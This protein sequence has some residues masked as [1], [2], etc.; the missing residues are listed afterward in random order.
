M[1]KFIRTIAAEIHALTYC[2]TS[3]RWSHEGVDLIRKMYATGGD[4]TGDE[5]RKLRELRIIR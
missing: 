3:P 5:L 1:M 2:L 4:L